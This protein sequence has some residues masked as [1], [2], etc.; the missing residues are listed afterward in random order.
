MVLSVFVAGFPGAFCST[1]F[2]RTTNEAQVLETARNDQ[3]RFLAICTARRS[4]RSEEHCALRALSHTIVARGGAAAEASAIGERGRLE[5]MLVGED[6]AR[7]VEGGAGL[8]AGLNSKEINFTLPRTVERAA[9]SRRR[10]G[11]VA[12][13]PRTG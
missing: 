4:H 12:P 3:R 10:R 9:W 1:F 11:V 5:G 2:R 13:T 7:R 8:F 6:G